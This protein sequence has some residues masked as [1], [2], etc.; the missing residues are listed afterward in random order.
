[1]RRAGLLNELIEIYTKTIV[2]DEY[3]QEVEELTLKQ[4]TR[5]KLVHNNGNRSLENEE[6]VHNYN[7]TFTVRYYVDIDDYDVIK[8]N[9]KYYRVLDVEPNREYQQK[10]INTEKIND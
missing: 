4:T 5:A 6:I 3:G 9:G 8:W 10:V 7:K 1:M 2:K